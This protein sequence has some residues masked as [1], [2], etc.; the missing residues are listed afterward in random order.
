MTPGIATILFT[1]GAV[2][3]WTLLAR[4]YRA[5]E[6]LIASALAWIALVGAVWATLALLQ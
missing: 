5:R 3:W 2:G 1:L 4:T 6:D